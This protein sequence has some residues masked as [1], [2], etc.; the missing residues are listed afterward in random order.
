MIKLLIAGCRHYTNYLEFRNKV[1]SILEKKFPNIE[2]TALSIVEGGARGVD[3]LA[4]TYAEK[5][6]YA[7]R[8]FEA[9]WENEGKKAGILRNIK[10]ADYCT[11]AIL[12]WDGESKGTGNMKYL[13]EE[14]NIPTIVIRIPPEDKEGKDHEQNNQ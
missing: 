10:M 2:R 7:Y 3:R 8:T 5:Q 4:R 6:S 1:N 13:L 9:D 14:R 12:F 11:H